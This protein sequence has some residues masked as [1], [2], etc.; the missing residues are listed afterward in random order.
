MCIACIN[1]AT[2]NVFDQFAHGMSLSIF[3]Y[4]FHM[5]F[6]VSFLYME[7]MCILFLTQSD[8]HS[9]LLNVGSHRLVVVKMKVY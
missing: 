2:C 5:L 3:Y 8:N 4:A 1:I 9:H 6:E 7:W